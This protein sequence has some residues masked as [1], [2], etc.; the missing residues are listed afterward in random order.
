LVPGC[1]GISG[2]DY[3]GT[4]ENGKSVSGEI[5]SKFIFWAKGESYNPVHQLSEKAPRFLV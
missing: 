5:S 4:K 1:N 3:T 2:G